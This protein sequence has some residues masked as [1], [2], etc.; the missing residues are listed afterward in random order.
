MYS[1]VLMMAVST[2]PDITT[3]G[4]GWN[5]CNGSS[6]HGYSGSSCYGSSCTGCNGGSCQGGFLGMRKKMGGFLGGNGFLGKHKSNGCSGSSCHGCTGSSC[7]G[8]S[9]H[10]M[11]I[12]HPAPVVHPSPCET[13]PLAPVHGDPMIHTGPDHGTP[14]M[15]PEIKK[16]PDLKKDEPKKM[17]ELKSEEPK[18]TTMAPA[19]IELNVPQGSKVTINGLTVGGTSEV[20][21]FQTLAL[22]RNSTETYNVA[23][24]VVRNGKTLTATEQLTVKGGETTSLTVIPQDNTLV[25]K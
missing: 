11:V 17:P 4:G 25:S 2:T 10:G 13:V 19:N 1:M 3:H 21:Y 23:V 24:E 7:H 12:V 20:R 16:M 15:S 5:G 8:S 14:K 22:D 18:K 6:C 9:C